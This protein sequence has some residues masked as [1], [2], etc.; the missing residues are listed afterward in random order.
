[1]PFLNKY[2]AVMLFLI[3]V[4]VVSGCVNNS[5]STVNNN[6]TQSN[7]QTQNN[8]SIDQDIVITVSYQGTWNGTISDSAG[9][10]T[11]Q[12]T[13]DRRFNLGKNQTSI[14]A[15]FQK[16]ENDNLQFRVE[17]LNGTTVIQSQTNNS[18]FGTISLNRTF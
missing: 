10:R 11:V 7:P 8:D 1:M 17:I 12:G 2:L 15:N 3:M 16:L 14:A 5:N 4:T 9:T 13:G 18:P 6:S